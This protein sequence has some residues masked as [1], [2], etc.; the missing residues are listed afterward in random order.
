MKLKI[1]RK[2]LILAIIFAFAGFVLTMRWWILFLNTLNPLL[3]LLVYYVIMY[4]SLYGL[5]RLD[6]TIFG[7]NIKK[8]LQV[9]GVT[10][11]TFA[12][13]IVVD[14]ES[15]LINMITN[16][17]TQGISN[18]Y[19]QAEDG[20]VWYIFSLIFGTAH[21]QLLRIFTYVITPFLLALAGGLLIKDKPEI[22]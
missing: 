19:F 2:E 8:P 15:P 17:T 12:F 9:L 11:I 13:F 3:G 5:S 16:G 14:W 22:R 21:I 7:F 6:L 18:V 10:L 4:S 20:A 1:T